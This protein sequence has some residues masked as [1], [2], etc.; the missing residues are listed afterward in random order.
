MGTNNAIYIVLKPG[1]A[2]DWKRG[3]Y[4]DSSLMEIAPARKPR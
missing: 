2:Y 4:V 1:V 3:S